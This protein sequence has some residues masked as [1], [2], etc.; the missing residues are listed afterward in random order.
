MR[1]GK[2]AEALLRRQVESWTT[3][4][5]GEDMPLR[6][7]HELEPRGP[8]RARERQGFTPRAGSAVVDYDE[9]EPN[10]RFTPQTRGGQATDRSEEAFKRLTP[11]RGED[12]LQKSALVVPPPVHPHA[13]AVSFRQRWTSAM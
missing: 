9:V 1:V 12:G 8:P 5:H 11:A 3:P 2:A 7:R 6:A 4:A 13:E 10:G